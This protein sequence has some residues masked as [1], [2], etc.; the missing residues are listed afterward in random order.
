MEATSGGT[1]QL[2]DNVANSG[3]IEAT[4]AASSVKLNDVTIA[5][6]TLSTG[7]VTSRSG[8]VIEVVAAAGANTSVLSGG[9]TVTN[10]S[11]AVPALTPWNDAEIAVTAGEQITITASG[12]A[13]NSPIQPARTPDGNSIPSD[14]SFLAPGLAQ[15]S[16]VGEIGLSGTPFEVGTGTTFTAFAS[17]ELH[18]SMNDNA[19]SDNSGSW[20]VTVTYPTETPVTVDGF[21]QVDAGANLELTGTVDNLGTIDLVSGVNPATLVIGGTVVLEGSGTVTLDGSTDAIVG[22]ST[23]TNQLDNFS[24]IS[25]AGTIGSSTLTLH[26][27][28]GGIID[29]NLAGQT[30]TLNTGS[31]TIVNTGTLEA[32]DGGTLDIESNVNNSS[33]GT[34]T[35][36][37]GSAV[38]LTGVIISGGTLSTVAGTGLL[39]QQ[40]AGLIE[41]TGASAIDNAT[42]SNSGNGT[43]EV[44]SGGTLTL[45]GDTINGCIL[46]GSGDIHGAAFNVDQHST[47][48]LNAVTVEGS[49][50]GGSAMVSNAGTITLEN[51]LTI[52]GM[53]TILDLSGG[54]SVL[55]NGSTIAVTD[56]GS[57]LQ[58]DRNTIARSAQI[59]DRTADIAFTNNSGAVDADVTSCT[60]TID[61]GSNTII[62]TGTLEASNGGTLDIDSNVRNS[63]GTIE[64]TGAG[65]QV[66][67]NNVT[68]AGGTLSTG[69]LTDHDNGLIAVEAADGANTSVLDGSDAAGTTVAGYVQV[70]SGA[71]LELIGTINN[72]GTI[73]VDGGIQPSIT[74][75]LEISR[76][77]TLT[78]GGTVTLDGAS[79]QIIAASS[80]GTLDNYDTISGAGTIG[81]ASHADALQRELASPSTPMSRATLSSTPAPIPSPI[82]PHRGD[83]RQHAAS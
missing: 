59:R 45:D 49:S 21:V 83:E 2:D 34:I 78:G 39:P 66:E 24:T 41:T 77:V 6:G 50:G 11:F 65:S 73:E 5:G 8:G 44:E 27:E 3:T 74:N 26:N 16:L 80:G 18:L 9:E 47:L 22:Q 13:F 28:T 64:A 23:G 61:S 81:I 55:L 58:N 60:L 56:A 4:G 15:Y 33:G 20:S 71:N 76:T 79:D 75:A 53:S 52:G 42:I 62:N 51:G 67:L 40:A 1:L 12:L 46:V 36:A 43:L 14:P 7:S 35:A 57:A 37:T 30:L 82:A 54:G 72:S 25:G 70:E 69:D 48:T 17:G 68:I 31:N 19:Y 63:G 10:S 29:A 38:D 32:T